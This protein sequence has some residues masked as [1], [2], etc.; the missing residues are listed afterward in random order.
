[1]L[2]TSF[3]NA[4]G[5]IGEIVLIFGSL[6]LLEKIDLCDD[7][8]FLSLYCKRLQAEE[9]SILTHG[10]N[11]ELY[12]VSDKETAVCI[13]LCPLPLTPN[14]LHMLILVHS[15]RTIHVK[16]AR[17]PEHL[18]R[19]R[20]EDWLTMRK[21][22]K[23]T[24][25]Y[26]L[27]RVPKGLGSGASVYFASQLKGLIERAKQAKRPRFFAR[28]MDDIVQS[29]KHEIDE[30][31]D[32][33]KIDKSC[34]ILNWKE[35]EQTETYT[36]KEMNILRSTALSTRDEYR[37]MIVEKCLAISNVLR[38]LSFLP[39]NEVVMSRN[40]G[41]IYIL[42]RLLRLCAD[43]QPVARPK[44]LI[45]QT[46]DTTFV[47]L[48]N[49][50]TLSEVARTLSPPSDLLEADDDNALMLLETANQLREDAFVI[51]THLS[52]QIDL[53]D[54]DSN[55]S[56]PVFDGL[57]HWSVSGCAEAKDPL[58]PGII[59]PRNY[60][61]ETLCKMSVIEHNVDL[62]I[63]TGPWSRTEMFLKVLA[64][65]LSMNEEVPYRE[66]AIVILSAMCAAS[67]AVCYVVAAETSAIHHLVTF[68]E[69]ADTNM[70]SVVQQHGMQALRDNPEMMGTSIGM[71]RRAAT[72]LQN[73]C[74]V[75]ACRKYFLKQQQRLLQFTMSQLMDS[76]VGAV[77]A[78]TLFE[79]QK[80]D[81]EDA[82]NNNKKKME[83]VNPEHS[84]PSSESNA[85]NMDEISQKTKPDE[86]DCN[87]TMEEKGDED[88]SEIETKK[89]C[90]SER[91]GILSN[92]ALLQPPPAKR[93]KLENGTV[94][95][96]LYKNGGPEARPLINGD[97][98][99]SSE[100]SP[101]SRTN[102]SAL[103]NGTASAGS[104]QA[105]A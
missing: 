42:G 6:F 23:L 69:V 87:I 96:H 102:A 26:F 15:G 17:V 48:P 3:P 84:K 27:S 37:Q 29:A 74:K 52:V 19:H 70:L 38:G 54:F 82:N 83:D 91:E 92:E 75:P 31:V 77:I 66:F 20:Q 21:D 60:A 28:K 32:Y 98:E 64:G 101:T 8:Y 18:R 63:S 34:R 12:S 30:V 81:D 62:L 89:S 103:E 33:E 93:Q 85:V 55:V 49:V 68:L 78:D 1:M 25:D 59:C 56:W 53:Y 46:L 44:S 94:L 61:L 88:C 24:A 16:N 72:L 36:E 35:K 50:G 5:M 39:G 79:I 58:L 40:A 51:M 9:T 80:D 97:V 71:L 90:R 105:V 41:L 11:V 10:L 13:R 100:S 2:S 65:L 57:L 99:S 14:T 22:E 86:V 67:E 45:K 104:I 4:G 73:L 7:V 47:K 43:E 76:R 95:N